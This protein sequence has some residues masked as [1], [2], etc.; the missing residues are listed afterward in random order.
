MQKFEF[1]KNLLNHSIKLNKGENILV[2]ILGEECVPLGKEFI[3]QA[4]DLGAKPYFN[5]IN[6]PVLKEMLLNSSEEQIKMYAKHDLERMK[7][8]DAYIGIRAVSFEEFYYNI[9]TLDYE[10]MSKAM[11]NLVELMNKTKTVRITGNG[12]DLTF[13]IDGIPAEKYIGLLFIGI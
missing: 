6:Y 4:E 13:S 1:N 10:K 5:I 8:M 3:K 7:D 2:E 12:T 11:D 9:C